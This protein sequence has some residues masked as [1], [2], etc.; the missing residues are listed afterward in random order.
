VVNSIIFTLKNL[1]NYWTLYWN[2]I[3]LTA[4]TIW[5]AILG[6]IQELGNAIIKFIN[7][8]I[9]IQQWAAKTWIGEKLGWKA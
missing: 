9:G 2:T 5:N 1:G 7:N 4:F 8:I 6:G 3:K